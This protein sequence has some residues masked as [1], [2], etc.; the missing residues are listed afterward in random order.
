[1]RHTEGPEFAHVGKDVFRVHANDAVGHL[2]DS[3]AADF[4]ATADGY[5]VSKEAVNIIQMYAGLLKVMPWPLRSPSV[6]ISM[7]AAE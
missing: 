3:K 1:M 2:L 7:Y 6:V 4:V 5:M